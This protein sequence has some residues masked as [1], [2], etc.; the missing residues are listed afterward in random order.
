MKKK[1]LLLNTVNSRY[2]SLMIFCDKGRI[3]FAHHFVDKQEDLVGALKKFSAKHKI[4]FS[5]VKALFL[6]E[7]GGSFT[8]SRA[9]IVLANA[10]GFLQEMRIRAVRPK[11]GEPA[12]DLAKRLSGLKHSGATTA[13]AHYS[14][15]PNITSK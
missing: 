11:D 5:G 3:L 15:K 12:E 14:G 2:P 7:G 1:F 8:A 10:L 13:K 6:M 9:G 4:D